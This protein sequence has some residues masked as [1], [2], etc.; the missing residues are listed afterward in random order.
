[1]GFYYYKKSSFYFI[2]FSASFIIRFYLLIP[3]ASDPF[4]RSSYF[5]ALLSSTI[6]IWLSDSPVSKILGLLERYESEEADEW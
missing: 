5:L 1:M 6:C 4:R 3:S 2:I